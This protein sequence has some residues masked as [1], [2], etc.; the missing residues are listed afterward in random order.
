[1]S[2]VGAL[3]R[4][5]FRGRLVALG[6][7]ALLIT[8]GLGTAIAALTAAWRTD[9]AYPDYLRRAEVSELVVN[10]SVV[11]DRMAE[12]IASAPGVVGVTADS[13]LVASADD[14]QPRTRGVVDTIQT[15]VR[16]SADGRYVE[17]DRPVIHEGRMVEDGAEAFL[18]LEAAAE[19]GVGVGDELPIA[20][21]QA[22]NLDLSEA[23]PSDIVEPIGRATVTVVGI[24]VFADEVLAEELYPRQ[25]VLVPHELIAPFDCTPGHP[26]DADAAIDELAAMLVP[27][28]CSMYYRYFSL[29]V[30]G[31]D[32]GVPAVVDWL[33]QLVDEENALLP[34]ALR[35]RDVGFYLVPAVTAEER[36]RVDRSLDPTVTALSLFGIGAGASTLALVVLGAVRLARR[37]QPQVQVWHMLGAPRRQRAAGV[38]LPLAAGAALGILGAV[39]FGWLS[40][41]I[42]P[43]G[44]ARLVDPDP[45]LVVVS[46]VALPAVGAAL[47]VLAAGILAAAMMAAGVTPSAS[48]A[49]RSRT[50]AAASRT[51]NVPL[52]LGVR[53]AVAGAGATALLSAGVGAVTGVL[54]SLVFSTNVSGLLAD[55]ARFGWPYDAAII[56]GYGYGGA[57]QQAIAD[58]LNRP[59][60]EAY[61]VAALEAGSVAVPGGEDDGVAQPI[62]AARDGFEDLPVSVVAG[63]L[64]VGDDQVA[65]GAQ[66]A[67]R[68]GVDVG[69]RVT[70]A[71]TYGERAGTV[72]GLV[73]I[74]PLGPALSD[75][76]GLG[77]GILLPG[78]F[79]DRAVAPTE[80]AAG[81][82]PRTLA[83]GVGSFIAIDLR[84]GVDPDR[85]LSEIYTEIKAGWDDYGW[86]PFIHTAPV[87]PAQ[88]ADVAGMRSVPVLLAGLIAIAMAVG[89]ALAVGLAVRT[90][91]R[92][93]AVLRVLGSTRG[94]LA[95]TLRWQALTIVG[96]AL[97][98]GLPLGLALGRVGW[99]GFARS[100]G[101]PTTVDV[102][103]PWVTMVAAAAVVIALLASAVPGRLAARLSPAAVLREQ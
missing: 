102:S 26:T 14:G 90:R 6:T 39:G 21:W 38:A 37:A 68:L 35:P 22:E 11:T 57:N 10:P 63:A 93:L 40:S 43:V 49:T 95:A 42:G 16:A 34:G 85:F 9:H 78:P 73:V 5:A 12:R 62:V 65:L 45:G 7:L 82:P 50:A 75:R 52:A 97:V 33:R 25:R 80:E 18:S 56:V 32:A 8:I 19:L 4:Q 67:A 24:G 53:A 27:R 15:Q 46:Q 77:T 87:R 60:V 72:S 99:R 83:D 94:Q 92:E 55:P 17:S 64:P 1:M 69:D 79:F 51:G 70:V 41:G 74:P 36:D 61:G 76:A 101:I 48:R 31:G 3:A 84:D 54:A 100:L 28:D 47:L 98:A 2:G 88:I 91:R 86:E 96:V 66:A 44:R 59:E 58:T 29:Q 20:F 103:V 13:L 30:A 89:L 81:V 23:D 71:T